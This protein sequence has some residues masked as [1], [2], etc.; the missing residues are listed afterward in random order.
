MNKKIKFFTAYHQQFKCFSHDCQMPIAHSVFKP[1]V[2][3][4]SAQQLQQHMIKIC[5][6]MISS[7]KRTFISELR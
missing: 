1:T 3:N 5:C 4:V 7:T 6:K 2:L